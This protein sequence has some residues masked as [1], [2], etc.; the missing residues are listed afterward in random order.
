MRIIALV[1]L[2]LAFAGDTRA[3]PVDAA[4]TPGSTLQVLRLNGGAAEG[5]A[6]SLYAEG[7]I[8][9]ETVADPYVSLPPVT[10]GSIE[11]SHGATSY[12]RLWLNSTAV[13]PGAFLYVEALGATVEASC[14]ADVGASRTAE[15]QVPDAIE[16]PNPNPSHDLAGAVEA[17][18]CPGALVR[19][20]GS[21][22][23][24]LWDWSLQLTDKTGTATLQTG[25]HATVPG[26]P[27]GAA[28]QVY[29]DAAV[30]CL[31]LRTPKG[32]AHVFTPE[33]LATGRLDLPSGVLRT[34]EPVQVVNQGGALVIVQTPTDDTPG[35]LSPWW[36]AGMLLT[37][38]L[39]ATWFQT[40]WIAWALRFHARRANRRAL[41]L[42]LAA[43]A[44][45]PADTEARELLAEV[46]LALS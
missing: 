4:A 25:Y 19:V 31:E 26:S 3:T 28:R 27:V 2:L 46:R 45:H 34:A 1:V 40:D 20:C 7:A 8:V 32:T 6:F 17:A 9:R 22:R 5:G 21:F 11:P 18:T 30:A 44:R 35:R 24:A 37:T 14:L 10:A 23:T 12:E 29:V 33:L 38:A 15:L 41:L 43:R 13:E 39:V 36:V 42:A 16:Q